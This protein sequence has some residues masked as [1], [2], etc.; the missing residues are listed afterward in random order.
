M[1]GDFPENDAREFVK[2]HLD[3]ITIDSLN[4]TWPEVYQVGTLTNRMHTHFSG[5]S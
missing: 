2:G 5:C 1:V 3:N 4:S